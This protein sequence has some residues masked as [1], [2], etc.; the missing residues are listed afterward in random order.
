ML[1]FLKLFAIATG[2]FFAIDM[3]W[4]VVVA[5]KFY[6]KKLG[7]LKAQKVNW[8]AAILFYV[9]FMAGLTYFAILPAVAAQSLGLA[10][11]NGAFFGLV[12][13]ATYDLTNLATTKNWPLTVTI[14]DLIWGTTVSLL[15][16]LFTVLIFI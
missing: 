9:L 8:V 16:T 6:T 14:V 2:L 15:V 4:L 13:Y 3:V 10:V 12:A 11:L 7:D 1:E 5:N